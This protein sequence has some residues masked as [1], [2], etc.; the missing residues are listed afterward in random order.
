[1]YPKL[2]KMEAFGSYGKYTEIDFELCKDNLFLISGPTGS[3]KTTIFDAI[4][5]AIYGAVSSDAKGA[6]SGD[7]LK[8]HFADPK[9]QAF[10]E[11]TFEHNGKNYVVRRTPAQW[12]TSK[13]SSNG[14]NLTHH[15]PTVALTIDGVEQMEKAKQLNDKLGEIVGVDADMFRQVG[16]LAQGEF[17]KVL[18]AGS[19]EK[20]EIYRQLFNTAVYEKIGA[21]LNARVADAKQKI[22][23]LT[24]K[25][26]SPLS[27]IELLEDDPDRETI[28]ALRNRLMETLTVQDFDALLNELGLA[29]ERLQTKLDDKQEWEAAKSALEQAK[30][31]TTEA[32][33]T[34]EAFQRL[35]DAK[36]KFEALAARQDEFNA[37]DLLRKSIEVAYEL[38][39]VYDL[40][41]RCDKEL[42]GVEALL[43]AK[44]EELPSLESA[45][46]NAVEAE[47]DAKKEADALASA[48]AETK[49]KVD[50]AVQ[51][52]DEL[53]KVEIELQARQRAY[54]AA[55]VA[56]TV[57][58]EAKTKHAADVQKWQ[59]ERDLLQDAGQRCEAA[60]AEYESWKQC[61]KSVD[62][63]QQKE[64]DVLRLTADKAIAEKAARVAKD[65][66]DRAA[67]AAEEA[68]KAYD[69]KSAVFTNNQAGFLAQTLKPGEPCPVCGSLEHP[70]PHEIAVDIRELT[71]DKVD[72]A[73]EN[74]DKARR[75]AAELAE[76]AA[77]KAADVAASVA[78]LNAAQ[79]ALTQTREQL[80]G[81]FDELGAAL[82]E[83]FTVVDAK[84]VVAEHKASLE[85]KLT[86]LNKDFER[87]T[88]LDRKVKESVAKNA[89][90][91]AGAKEASERKTRALSDLTQV[92]ASK[93]EK[94]EL[95]KT[96][97]FPSKADAVLAET[98]LKRQKDAADDA[99]K[100]AQ[101]RKTAADKAKTE[102][103]TTIEE[104]EKRVP[105]L[106]VD[107]DKFKSEYDVKLA[108]K[109][110]SEEAWKT[111][112][113]A[114]R[115]AEAPALRQEVEAYEQDKA[116]AIAAIETCKQALEGKETPDMDA[117]NA[118]VVAAQEI[119]DGYDVKRRALEDALK[120]NAESRNELT[121]LKKQF[122]SQL[123]DYN[124]VYKLFSRLGGKETG[125]RVDLETFVQRAYLE[126]ILDYANKRLFRLSSG[127][128]ELRL[129]EIEDAATGSN[130]GLDL[131]IYDH[132]NSRT[133][134]V[135]TLSG[136]E[137]FAAAMAL[138]LGT[139][140][141]IQSFNGGVKLDV[142]FIDEGFGTLDQ[143]KLGEAIRVVK[144][145]SGGSK[146]VG[147]VSH[148]EALKNEFDEQLVVTCDKNGS[149]ARWREN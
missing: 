7:A 44:R 15:A 127:R 25:A 109:Q 36:R 143:N 128:Y 114:R 64:S 58:D 100:T 124:R 120:R 132:D 16:I 33:G 53:A 75:E 42:N 2:L 133:R 84:N 18:R 39:A 6:K 142:L 10:V 11:L 81:R 40:F 90:L 76:L 27:R 118:R 99:Y 59:E 17:M 79:D 83:G 37:K 117:L 38:K 123:L 78:S 63:L 144:A 148:V 60:K 115:Q 71:V 21:A 67:N 29:C 24:A 28:V 147:I 19:S 108:E 129:K 112:V 45:A 111:T 70:R 89:E 138:A 51:V 85:A 119:F 135:N 68:K 3:G 23:G 50:Q 52:F 34:L 113:N 62:A 66:A 92:Q 13:R 31:A 54:D 74:A 22:A 87:F 98:Q 8:S 145:C 141:H 126:Q 140:D 102:C 93:T 110:I 57:A 4:M 131:L 12:T 97:A 96:L 26:S 73:R 125:A 56:E 46:Q 14:A 88:G 136:G 1:M 107:R 65:N 139:A 30:E 77:N 61:G 9:V 134:E 35:E 72:K 149:H 116:G 122:E 86:A 105:T 101:A 48:F 137:S 95:L 41:E 5:F 121:T 20:K 43:K 69:E 32:R 104:N 49:T 91:E 106:Q 146:L 55:R 130:K 80:R 94:E 47:A 82:A 103:A